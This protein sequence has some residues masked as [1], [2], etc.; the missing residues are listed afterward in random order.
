MFKDHTHSKG[1]S[2]RTLLKSLAL[3]MGVDVLSSLSPAFHSSLGSSLFSSAYAQA[4][5]TPQKRVLLFFTPNGTV[6]QHFYPTGTERNFTISPQSMLAPLDEIKDDLIIL[7][8]LNFLTGNNHEGGMES[9]LTNGHHSDSITH[10][11]SLDQYLV[12]SLQPSTP[13]P[14]LELGVMTDP[15]GASIQTRMSYQSPGQYVHPDSDPRSVFRRLFGSSEV[16]TDVAARERGYRQ[17]VLDLVLG[18]LNQ[19]RQKVGG[20]PR[21]KLDQHLDSIRT[22]ERRLSSFDQI[23]CDT[24]PS[25]PRLSHL[26]AQL[27]PDLLQTQMDLALLALSCNLTSIAS[28]QFSHTV[29]PLVFSWINQSDSHHSLSHAGNGTESLNQ[30]I[31]AEQWCATQFKNLVNRLKATPDSIN[32]GTLFDHTITIWIKEMG[33]SRLHICDSVPFVIAGSGGGE[34]ETGRFLQCGG[35]SHS[36]LLVSIC[37]AMGL[38]NQTFGNPTTGVGP[39]AQLG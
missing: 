9:M 12:H 22:L 5:S 31:A 13:L 16:D 25:P 23:E 39:L 26:E 8:G 10:G 11:M 18:D 2:R 17:S 30:F 24:P 6:P 37:Q 28:I 38:T 3:G 1:W 32:G 20:L 21:Q 7:E 19:L 27:S 4:P 36:H 15:W 14:S 34:W 35:Q 29:S 33:D